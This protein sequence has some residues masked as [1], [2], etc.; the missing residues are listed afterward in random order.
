MSDSRKKM[1]HNGNLLN[2][3]IIE[4]GKSAAMISREMGYS[5]SLVYHLL[6][7]E[8]LKMQVFWRLGLV[9]NRN[10]LAEIA[11]DFPVE[12]RSK[13]ELKLESEIERLK[14]EFEK[15]L[16]DVKKE[17]EVYRRLFDK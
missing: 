8:S 9:M 12:H 2:K 1:P 14:K 15:E 13:R 10:V 7:T 17:L 3:Y 16:N 4:S 5:N 11:E 6:P